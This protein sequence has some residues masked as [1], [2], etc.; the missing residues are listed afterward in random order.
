M[1]YLWSLVSPTTSPPDPGSADGPVEPNPPHGRAKAAPCWPSLPTGPVPTPVP[2]SPCPRSDG[3]RLGKQ[4][5]GGLDRLDL[6]A[7]DK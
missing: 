7:D 2:C 1:P 6:Y 5:F 3:I 4:T